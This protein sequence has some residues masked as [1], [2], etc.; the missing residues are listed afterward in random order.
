MPLKD[1]NNVI[2]VIF[3]VF[4]ALLWAIWSFKIY[5]IFS[6][7][8]FR[9]IGAAWLNNP[10]FRR[11]IEHETD[12]ILGS[13]VCPLGKFGAI[14]IIC[15]SILLVVLLLMVNIL[16]WNTK[17][18]NKLRIALQAIGWTNVGIIVIIAI[19]SLVLNPHLFIRTLPFYFLEIGISIMILNNI[20][21]ESK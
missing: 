12:G 15:W 17:D 21:Q 20:P 19:I 10:D 9:D 7:K 3:L 6:G 13:G 5:D 18:A 14:F 16:Y 2:G 11:I 4:P 8:K 1:L